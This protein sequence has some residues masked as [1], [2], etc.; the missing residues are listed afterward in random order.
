MENSCP[1]AICMMKM[2]VINV[3]YLIE[4]ARLLKATQIRNQAQDAH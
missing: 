3:P 1:P 2:M 4:G